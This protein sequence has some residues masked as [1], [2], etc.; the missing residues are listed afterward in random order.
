MGVQGAWAWVHMGAVA[1]AFTLLDAWV[2]QVE[3]LVLCV[4]L[5]KDEAIYKEKLPLYFP[6]G[7][8]TP[9]PSHDAPDT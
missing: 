9:P 1:Q 4:F 7:M 3:R 6:V 8:E 5:E 2:P